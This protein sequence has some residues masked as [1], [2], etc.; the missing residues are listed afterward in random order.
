VD[1]DD[2]EG[3]QVSTL[4]NEKAIDKV[5]SLILKA[6]KQGAKIETGGAKADNSTSDLFYQPTVISNVKHSMTIAQEEIFGPVA[7]IIAFKNE[8][9]AI[10]ISNA[11][12]YGL[13]AYFFTNYIY[14]VYR[15][16]KK[17]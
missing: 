14:L 3:N 1:P 12:P 17:L 2:K 16:S 6:K 4:I 10:E 13:V 8:N 7:P 9:E 15:I 5:E 11:S